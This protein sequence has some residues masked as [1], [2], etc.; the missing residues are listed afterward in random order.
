MPPQ[1]ITLFDILAIA[2]MILPIVK[3]VTTIQALNNYKKQIEFIG[4][5]LIIS[6]L[7]IPLVTN[8]IHENF[9]KIDV[10][11]LFVATIIAIVGLILLTNDIFEYFTGRVLNELVMEQNELRLFR[12]ENIET[13]ETAETHLFNIN[14]E[15]TLFNVLHE[16]VDSVN[17]YRRANIHQGRPSALYND[18]DSRE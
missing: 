10:N 15:Y 16:T 5:I 4:S 6:T 2:F 1:Y 8:I 13:I 11:D 7:S 3:V 12:E 14:D 18:N 9:I 17:F